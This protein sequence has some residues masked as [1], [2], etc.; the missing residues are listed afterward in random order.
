MVIRQTFPF[1]FDL[2]RR[3]LPPRLRL[4]IGL[5]VAVHA[6]VGASLLYMRFNPPAAAPEPAERII[7]VPII[8]WTPPKLDEPAPTPKL[9]PPLHTPRAIETPTVEPLPAQPPEE[10]ATTVIGPVATIPPVGSVTPVQ[11]EPA[12]APEPVV[13]RPNWVRKP[14]GAEMARFYPEGALRRGTSGLAVIGCNVTAEGAVNG[15][16]VVSET[17]T[18]EGF[19]AAALKLSRF[20]RMSPQTLDG[21]PVDGATV[22]IPIRFSLGE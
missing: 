21:R 3:V 6:A 15:C 8:D 18:G 1:R 20:F 2:P 17:P 14:S 13:I 19:G 4:A 22:S 9:T 7:E 5:S 12:L 16:R 10:R 11:A